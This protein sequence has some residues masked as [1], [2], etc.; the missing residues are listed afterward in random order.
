M[1]DHMDHVQDAVQAATEAAIARVCSA[2]KPT[3]RSQC[4]Q[5]GE[6]VGEH[7]TALGA[8]LCLVCQREAEAA[9]DRAKGRRPRP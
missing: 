7:R 9:A 1:P 8:C 4:M 5:C 3:G 6:P 2:P